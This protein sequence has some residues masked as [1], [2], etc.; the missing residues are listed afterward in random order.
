MAIE[1]LRSDLLKLTESLLELIK[2]FQNKQIPIMP[3]GA[4]ELITKYKIPEGKQLG[5]KLKMIEKEWA[6]NNFKISDQQIDNII[7]D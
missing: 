6:G 3:I 4:S 1:A 5:L 7:K 2:L